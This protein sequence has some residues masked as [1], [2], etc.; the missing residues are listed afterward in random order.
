MCSSTKAGG[1]ERR[2]G[3]LP[4]GL[5]ASL[6]FFFTRGS[7]SHGKQVDPGVAGA[8]RKL[9]SDHATPG[10]SRRPG[11]RCRNWRRSDDLRNRRAGRGCD[12][13]LNC[14]KASGM[15]RGF[16]Y[17]WP[18][19]Q[20]LSWPGSDY[21]AIGL[22]SPLDLLH[23]AARRGLEV[24]RLSEGTSP[25]GK[26]IAQWLPWFAGGIA[27]VAQR[28]LQGQ[29]IHRMSEREPTM[30]GSAALRFQVL[31][32]SV[33][34]VTVDELHRLLE[35]MVRAGEHSLVLNVNVHALNLASTL[36]WLREFYNKARLVFCDGAG[37]ILGA[38]ILGHRIP[39]R[40]T[41]ADWMWQLAEFAAKH[42]LSMFFLGGRPGVAEEAAAKLRK[43]FP[44]LNIVGAHHGY[45]DKSAGGPDSLGII[46]SINA[47]RPDL[48]IVGFG[49]PLQERWLMENWEQI[50][51]RVALTGGAVFDYVS[52]RLRRPPQ[53]MTKHGLEWLGRVLIEPRRLW[54]RYLVG[55]PSFLWRVL[56]Q[57]FGLDGERG[58]AL[59]ER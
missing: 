2:P 51:A 32:V 16:T 50:E 59:N 34:A 36:P 44:D 56:K 14:L 24:R 53:W 45:Y 31:G 19:V 20:G 58:R 57:R 25:V 13:W 4:A 48:L 22:V 41:Y 27:F 33:D 21:D 23:F 10:G 54:R 55:N 11:T 17:R 47:V 30:A 18:L 43:R 39:Q 3:V 9:R 38:R 15:R 37:V 7:R 42:G 12:L 1:R 8:L 28:P 49:M 5:G 46:K 6:L 26:V 29:G 40:I 52:G 35:Q